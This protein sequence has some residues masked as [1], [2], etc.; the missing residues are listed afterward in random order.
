[1]LTPTKNFAVKTNTAPILIKLL[2]I[3]VNAWI[4][5]AS[6]KQVTNNYH[7]FLAVNAYSIF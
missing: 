6:E 2:L 7:Q 1:M 5:M 3:I 4:K